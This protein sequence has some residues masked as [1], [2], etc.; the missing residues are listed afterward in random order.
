MWTAEQLAE[1]SANSAQKAVW[2]WA[3]AMGPDAV[4]ALERE[5]LAALPWILR[6]YEGGSGLAGQYSKVWM[7]KQYANGERFEFLNKGGT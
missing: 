7:L 2:E 1:R 5:M 3:R 6:V 4:Y